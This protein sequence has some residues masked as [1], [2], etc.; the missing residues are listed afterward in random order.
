MIR[1]W[2]WCRIRS[3]FKA[4]PDQEPTVS[5]SSKVARKLSPHPDRRLVGN[6]KSELLQGKV[7]W[8]KHANFRFN[9]L[10][11]EGALASPCFH[12]QGRCPRAT[13][14]GQFRCHGSYW[15]GS[16]PGIS[17]GE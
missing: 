8:L 5:A 17:D 4:R 2:K 11:E 3:G 7:D 16:S 9:K 12:H 15:R 13:A 6:S 1:L 14:R 10:I